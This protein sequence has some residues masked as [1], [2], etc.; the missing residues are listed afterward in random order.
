VEVVLEVRLRFPL[1]RSFVLDDHWPLD[2]YGSEFRFETTGPEVTAIILNFCNQSPD[3]AP[4]ITEDH[5]GPIK[6]HITIKGGIEATGRRIIRRFM[7]YAN[8]YFSLDIDVDA[9]EAEYIPANDEERVLMGL[10]AFKS[11]KE[12]P[13]SHLPFNMLAQAFFAGESSDDPSFAAR[14]FNLARESLLNEQ[15]ID[16]FRY[17]F[18]LF[19]AFYGDGKFRTEALIRAFLENGSFKSILVETIEVIRRDPLYAGSPCRAVVASHPTPDVLASYLVDRR[20]FYFHGNLVRS[21]A[22]HPDRQREAEPLADLCVQIAGRVSS[23]CGGAMFT[24]EINSRF[25]SNARTH[26]AIMTIEVQF[27]FIDPHNV[28]RTEDIN[29]D[30]PGT[31]ATSSLAIRVN[32]HFLQWAEVNLGGSKLLSAIARDKKSHV[33]IFRSE[34]LRED[35][36][37]TMTSPVGHEI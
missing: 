24:P 26:G 8:L 5:K 18:L 34:Y 7:D 21:N 15:Y 4:S 6:T 13:I 35:P 17:C 31:I 1:K 9:M 3:L 2:G 37:A 23:S 36:A 29:V 32:Q 28:T 30:V 10:Y 25:M 12:R 14:M 11:K 33:E 27:R 16:A 19:E 22:W 20:G